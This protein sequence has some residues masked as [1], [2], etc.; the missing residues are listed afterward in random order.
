MVCEEDEE[1]VSSH[2]GIKSLGRRVSRA[3]N[4]KT[5][6]RKFQLQE[7]AFESSSRQF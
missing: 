1:V 3:S 2:F 6:D 4:A 5:S 7:C